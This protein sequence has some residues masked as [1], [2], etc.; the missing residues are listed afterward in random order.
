MFVSAYT[1][2][3][4]RSA[5]AASQSHAEVLRALDLC[6]TGGNTALLKRWLS[7]WGIST[8][9]FDARALRKPRPTAKPLD[10][11]LVE[12]SSY[13]RANLKARLYAEG[14]KTPMCELCDQD[15]LWR[16]RPMGLILDHV[17]GVRDDNRLE[18][19]RIVCP[20]CAATLD[21]HCGRKNRLERP[22]R[23]C[24][25]CNAIFRARYPQQRYCSRACG[26]RYQRKGKP[27][28]ALRRIER[29]PYDVLLAEIEASSYL[30]VGRKYGVSDN[31]IRKWV[32]Q[33]EREQAAEREPDVP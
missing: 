13:A 29:P 18:N 30:A 26:I 24:L 17:N 7:Q 19:L 10:E 21:T 22:E 8:E 2:A 23:S 14:I 20:N 25:R 27:N 32:R 31:A 28:P 33:Y 11:I 16:G 5:V 4:A 3:E 12:R 6:P 1:E 9:H 15:E